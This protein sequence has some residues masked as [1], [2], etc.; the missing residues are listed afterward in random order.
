MMGFMIGFLGV[1]LAVMLM[2]V[3]GI[4]L[5]KPY[6]DE[7][8]QCREDLKVATMPDCA[9]CDCDCGWLG[10]VWT[11]LGGLIM[12]GSYV[13]LFWHNK[14]MDKRTAEARADAERVKKQAKKEAAFIIKEAKAAAKKLKGCKR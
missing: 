13:I 1:V 5:I 11:I 6:F 4:G 10:I 12:A 2:N 9:P 7:Y 3:F 14:K 8:E